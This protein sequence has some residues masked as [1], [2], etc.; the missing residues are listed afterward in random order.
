MYEK[1][2]NSYPYIIK[3]YKDNWKDT[4]FNLSRI[5]KDIK[6]KLTRWIKQ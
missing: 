1:Y 5:K 4:R 6:K 3:K 2:L